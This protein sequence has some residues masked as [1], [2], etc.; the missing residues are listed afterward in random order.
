MNTDELTERIRQ[1]GD[2]ESTEATRPIIEAVLSVL[3]TRAMDGEAAALA[4][5]L[6]RGFSEYIENPAE[7]PEEFA[8]DEFLSRVQDRLGGTEQEA[9]LATKAVLSSLADAV[10]EG[11]Q[12]SFLNALPN[13]LSGYARWN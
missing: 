8:A 2:Y 4:A 13:D 6:P 10:T 1:R 9:Q 12:V 7:K 11:E 3:G 5:Q